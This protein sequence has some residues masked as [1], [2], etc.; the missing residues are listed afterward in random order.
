MSRALLVAF[1]LLGGTSLFFPVM[2][3]F[4]CTEA[5]REDEGDHYF[6][7]IVMFFFLNAAPAPLFFILGVCSE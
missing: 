3:M 6:F 2:Y 1:T 4:I 5:R 7:N